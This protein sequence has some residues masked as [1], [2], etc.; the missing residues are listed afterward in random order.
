MECQ[1]LSVHVVHET[2]SGSRPYLDSNKEKELSEFLQKCSSVGYGKTRKDVLS[3]TETYVS[4]K[5]KLKKRLV[6]DGGAIF[7]G[8]TSS[9]ER[10]ST[11]FLP[12]R[13]HLERK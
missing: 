4:N 10:D 8:I 11:F 5:G 1:R 3:I 6:M 13:G 12:F 7:L 9:R 2:K